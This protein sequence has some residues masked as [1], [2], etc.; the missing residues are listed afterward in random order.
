MPWYVGQ[1]FA[2]PVDLNLTEDEIRRATIEQN[3]DN[4]RFQPISEWR[5]KAAAKLPVAEGAA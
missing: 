4:P 1:P 3:K 5:A 2:R